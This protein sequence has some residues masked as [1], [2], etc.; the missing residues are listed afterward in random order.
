MSEPREHCWHADNMEFAT[1]PSFHYDTCCHCG[2]RRRNG[3]RFS[4][5]GHGPHLL[6]GVLVP[7]IEDV[8]PC[9]GGKTP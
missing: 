4:T 8:G 9:A 7:D 1:Y 6:G 3:S 2:K 5:E